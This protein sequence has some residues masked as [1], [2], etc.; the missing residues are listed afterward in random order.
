MPVEKFYSVK[1]ACAVLGVRP[2]KLWELRREG[3][4]KWVR[5]GNRPKFPA[6]YIEAYQ[7]KVMGTEAPSSGSGAVQDATDLTN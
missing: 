5:V 4:I 3:K 1:E 2:T 6:S 7:R